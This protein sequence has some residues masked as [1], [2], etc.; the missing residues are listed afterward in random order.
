[1]VLTLQN[2]IQG[3][4]PGSNEDLILSSAVGGTTPTTGPANDIKTAA[5]GSLLE[6][7]VS[8]P[9]GL[10]NLQGYYLVA[11]LFSTG[12]PLAQP[13]LP[14]I[15]VNIPTHFLLIDGS[16]RPLLGQPVINPNGGTS[17][18]FFAPTGLAGTSVMVQAVVIS[19]S[20]ANSVYAASDAHEIRL[21]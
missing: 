4:Y 13:Q 11:D 3:T 19:P 12:S 9:G 14:Y 18:Y 17:A 16:P 6:F 5:G 7:N 2:G 1:M 21:Q 15:R 8:S 10:F 20:A